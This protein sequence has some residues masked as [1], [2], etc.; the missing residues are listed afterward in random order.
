MALEL[1]AI[2]RKA[3]TFEFANSPPQALAD[4]TAHLAEVE[5]T[6]IGF[7]DRVIGNAHEESSARALLTPTRH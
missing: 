2:D 5:P 7:K 6:P 1:V 4:L 3:V